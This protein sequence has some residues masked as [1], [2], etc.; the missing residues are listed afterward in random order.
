MSLILQNP[1]SSFKKICH[2]QIVILTIP[3]LK[4]KAASMTKYNNI[5]FPSHSE[6]TPPKNTLTNCKP[7]WVFNWAQPDQR[8]KQNNDAMKTILKITTIPLGKGFKKKRRK[9]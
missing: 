3:N 6:V 2:E 5:F 7:G 4:K 1:D 9:V 8:N